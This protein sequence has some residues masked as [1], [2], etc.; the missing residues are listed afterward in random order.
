MNSTNETFATGKMIREMERANVDHGY[1]PV[2]GELVPH[3]RRQLRGREIASFDRKTKKKIQQLNA[4]RR[5]QSLRDA[6][7]SPVVLAQL[8]ALRR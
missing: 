8:A 1:R 5:E 7:N 3:A 2:P 6:K 4:K